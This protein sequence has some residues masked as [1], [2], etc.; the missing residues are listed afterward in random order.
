[1]KIEKVSV[2]VP[3]YNEEEAI[4]GDLR[5]IIK[6]MDESGRDYEV[7]VVTS[8]GHPVTTLTHGTPTARVLREQTWLLGPSAVGHEGLVPQM[9]RQLDIP[10]DRQRIFQSHAAALEE[11]KRGNGVALALAFAVS[12]DLANGRLIAVS[13][14]SLAAKG[15]WTTTTLPDH[16]VVPAAAE[17]TR[18]VTTPRATQA[19]LKG[20]GVNIGH[21]RPSVHVTLWK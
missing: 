1:M 8:P 13:G 15:V 11:T 12:G 14:P 3:V 18:F 7:I 5:T 2:V 9:L 10:E 20:S 16:N 19:M 21:F 6:A 4:A 17:L